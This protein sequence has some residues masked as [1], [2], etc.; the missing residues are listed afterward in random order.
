MTVNACFQGLDLG[1]STPVPS[2]Q[3][4]TITQSL[5][6]NYLQLFTT[7]TACNATLNIVALTAHLINFNSRLTP[8]RISLLSASIPMILNLGCNEEPDSHPVH[9]PFN[10]VQEHLNDL[11]YV[12]ASV[13]F[14][15]LIYFGHPITGSI[16][17]GWVVYRTLK[18]QYQW[19]SWVMNNIEFGLLLSLDTYKFIYGD[20]SIRLKI[21]NIKLLNFCIYNFNQLQNAPST[22]RKLHKYFADITSAHSLKLEKIVINPHLPRLYQWIGPQ[23]ILLIARIVSEQVEYIENDLIEEHMKTTRSNN[24]LERNSWKKKELTDENGAIKDAYLI[25][26]LIKKGVFIYVKDNW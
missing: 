21:L 3:N 4:G 12:A 5:F 8:N 13:S 9:R 17:L 6:S 14:C 26:F 2:F 11:L 20:L 19:N 1:T 15:T 7:Y 24:P 23:T 10:F 22:A 25:Y 18:V 16:A